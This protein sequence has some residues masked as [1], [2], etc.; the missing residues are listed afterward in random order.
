M[1]INQICIADLWGRGEMAWGSFYM[2][3]YELG[4]RK[5]HGSRDDG[6]TIIYNICKIT[7]LN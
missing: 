5:K 4:E 7:N 2:C 6:Y 3:H 1:S